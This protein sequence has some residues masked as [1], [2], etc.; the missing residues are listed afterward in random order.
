VEIMA[1]LGLTR[2]EMAALADADAVRLPENLPQVL[3]LT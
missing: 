1:E 3:R 2:E